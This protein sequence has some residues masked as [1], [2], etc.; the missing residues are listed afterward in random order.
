[1]R[2]IRLLLAGTA[3]VLTNPANAANE[4]KFGKA[5]AW[6]VSQAIP[7]DASGSSDAPV[8][9][10]LTDQ[11]SRLEPG[12]LVT[13]SELAMKIQKPEGLAAGNISIPWDPATDTVTVNKLEIH[14]GSQVIDVLAAGQKFITLRRES[15]LEAAMLDGRLT[16]NIQP[17]GL[18]EG[19]VIDLATTIYHAAP[20][21]GNHV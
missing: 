11:Q 12:K 17:E 2:S 19:D 16:P 13:Y 8:A 3:V 10:L 1:M 4:L 20:L 5:P 14:R 9:L 7:A 15:G 21:L 6:V 18:Q